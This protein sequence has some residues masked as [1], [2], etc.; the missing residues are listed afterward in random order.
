MSATWALFWIVAEFVYS[1]GF[2]GVL[3]AC[4]PKA[5]AVPIKQGAIHSHLYNK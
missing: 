4:A 1:L 5:Y 3:L 2:T